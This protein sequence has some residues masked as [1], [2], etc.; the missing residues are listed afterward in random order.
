MTKLIDLILQLLDAAME[1]TKQLPPEEAAAARQR[2]Q[3]GID[4]RAATIAADEAGDL[5]SIPR[6]DD[7]DSEND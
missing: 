5:I 3:A 1:E 4:A 7:A 6:A 2:L